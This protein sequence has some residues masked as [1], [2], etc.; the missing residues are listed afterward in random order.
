MYWV[1]F[2]VSCSFNKYLVCKTD[3]VNQI[4]EDRK[5]CE[6]ANSSFFVKGVCIKANFNL[7]QIGVSNEFSKE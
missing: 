1:I 6:Q 3:Y 5:T 2:F 4:Y 7:D